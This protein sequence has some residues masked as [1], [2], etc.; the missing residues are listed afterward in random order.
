M[1]LVVMTLVL[2]MT[3]GCLVSYGG[4]DPVTAQADTAV[5]EQIRA[6]AEDWAKALESRDGKIRYAMMS[7]A[8][9]ESF[10]A[11]QKD[12]LGEDW[13]YVIGWSSPWVV[14]YSVEAKEDTAI[15][16]YAMQDSSPSQYT[17][18]EL[19][20][21]DVENNKLV[22][23]NHITSNL[24]WDDGKVCPVR[25]SSGMELEEGIWDFLTQAGID[26]E[27]SG[28]AQPLTRRS[29]ARLLYDIQCLMDTEVV[30]AFYWST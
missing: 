28:E 26:F 11:E 2:T 1:A 10:I 19:L 3:C 7:Q 8:E 30:S 29:A 25:S 14:S 24:Y 12:A 23:T 20:Q 5:A 9:K 16:T 13:N 15:I 18:K 6:M 17:M 4:S 27:I 22:V 21:F